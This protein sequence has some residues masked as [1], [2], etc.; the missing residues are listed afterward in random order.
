MKGEVMQRGDERRDRDEREGWWSELGI[1][2]IKGERK[3]KGNE[4]EK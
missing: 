2:R 3:R 4:G 1:E